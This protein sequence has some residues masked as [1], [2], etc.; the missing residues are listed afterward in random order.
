VALELSGGHAWVRAEIATT[1]A[2]RGDIAAATEIF[3]QLQNAPPAERTMLAAGAAAA[4][5]R[6]DD[7]FA[8]VHESIE[9]KE[10]IL[11]AVK[12][13]PPLALLRTDPRWRPMLQRIGLD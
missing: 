7:A 8:I 4:L 12:H 2:V 6:L 9:A 1:L 5:G 11:V 3:E 13:W 10:P